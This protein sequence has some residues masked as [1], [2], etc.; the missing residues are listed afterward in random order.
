MRVAALDAL[1]VRR[2]AA[3]A[4]AARRRA[5]TSRSRRSAQVVVN[6]CL[7]GGAL[8]IF[9][10]PTLPAP[11][12]AVVGRHPDHRRAGA[13]RP[14]RWASSAGSRA[15]RGPARSRPPSSSPRHG[16]RRGRVDPGRAGRRR[17]LRRAGRQ[18][19]A[20]R[21]G[22][23]RDR[24][25]RRRAGPGPHPGRAG[26][27]RPHAPRRSRCRSWPSSS[28]PYAGRGSTR[29]RAGASPPTYRAVDRPGLRDDRGGRCRTPLTTG[30][31]RRR[32]LVLRD[33]LPGHATRPPR[34]AA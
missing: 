2:V 8:E 14:A 19:D 5:S 23:G 3:A 29:R 15:R 21:G 9:L 4:G 12:I 27:R 24:A 33:R 11:L 18:P 7:S 1:G 32:P 6:P 10:E 34:T 31:R 22:A 16:A 20:G 28:R 30:R 26:H 25:D 17:R 13:D